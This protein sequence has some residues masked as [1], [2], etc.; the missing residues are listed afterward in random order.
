MKM[1]GGIMMAYTSSRFG[2]FVSFF[3]VSFYG[4]ERN[5]DLETMI[6]RLPTH[7]PLMWEEEGTFLTCE[8]YRK[9]N[10]FQSI[11][12]FQQKRKLQEHSEDLRLQASCRCCHGRHSEW[13]GSCSE[14]LSKQRGWYGR[15]GEAERLG[16]LMSK[17]EG[18]K[19][20]EASMHDFL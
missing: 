17:E 19:C 10:V 13:K 11:V 3:F 16:V 14:G 9:G 6:G 8:A 1:K 18:C 15:R 12:W 4:K 2:F 20:S 7:L 5:I